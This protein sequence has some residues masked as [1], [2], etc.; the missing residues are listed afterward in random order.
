MK[1]VVFDLDGTLIDS[2]PDIARAVAS[3]L[4][5]A[6]RPPLPDAT[7]RGFVGEG[8]PRLIDKVMAA[9]GLP[10]DPAAHARLMAG[11]RRAYDAAPARDSALFPGV[12]ALLPRL[13][14]E[15]FA[16]GLCTN[17]PEAPSRAILDGFGLAPLFGCVIGGDS[18]PLRK[19]DPAPLR[20]ALAGLGAATG[21]FV[22]DSMIVFFGDRLPDSVSPP[23]PGVPF[24]LY[25]E[26][27]RHQRVAD[28]P[29]DWAFADFAALPAIL[30]QAFARAA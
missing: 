2:V 5:G 13:A 23:P 25:T 16:L 14:A 15:G 21:L 17:K 30:A 26:G 8:V 7:I 9:A 3:A 27:Y 12:A 11:F 29:F 24:A 6:G 22:G 1:A 18:L 4:A 10:P 28:I 20:A 19:P